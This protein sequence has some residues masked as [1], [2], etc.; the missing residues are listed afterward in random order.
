MDNEHYL[1]VSDLEPPEPLIRAI[2]GVK[3]LAAGQ[4]L[5][6]NHRIKPCL[7]YENLSRL[8]FDSDT[9]AGSSGMCEVFIWRQGDL[10]AE[11]HARQAACSLPRWQD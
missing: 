3:G 1:D 4:Y 7:L 8:G 11:Q 6:L 2:D 5:H 9:R 10:T